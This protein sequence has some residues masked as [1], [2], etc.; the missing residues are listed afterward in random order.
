[1]EEPP[2]FGHADQKIKK[3]E[4]RYAAAD[5]RVQHEGANARCIREE[6]IAFPE[7]GPGNDRQKD[8]EFKTEQDCDD[9]KGSIHQGRRL[10]T[11]RGVMPPWMVIS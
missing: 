2:H 8:R 11:G 10:A 1:M 3:T 9:L 6:E 4:S 5:K 7:A